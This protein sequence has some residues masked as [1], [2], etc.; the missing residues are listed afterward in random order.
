MVSDGKG[1]V[2]LG[3]TKLLDCLMT[4]EFVIFRLERA[5]IR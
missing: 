5:V 1:G 2:E 3:Y 4:I